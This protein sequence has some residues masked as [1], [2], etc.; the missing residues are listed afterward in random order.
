MIANVKVVFAMAFNSEGGESKTMVS[1]EFTDHPEIAVPD[2]IKELL[3]G[4]IR[5]LCGAMDAARLELFS[6]KSEKRKS[7]GG[8]G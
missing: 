3:I 6:G 5:M 7:R 8:Q 1:F 4:E 2:G